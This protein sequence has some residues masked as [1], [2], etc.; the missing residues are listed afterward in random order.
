MSKSVK[1]IRNSIMKLLIIIVICWYLWILLSI[2][3]QCLTSC[4]SSMHCFSYKISDFGLIHW[5]E[6]MN[7]KL[8][9]E[10]LTARGNISYIPPETFTQCPDPPGTTFD[11]YRWLAK[12][13][14]ENCTIRVTAFSLIQCTI[15]N[16]HS[17]T[18]PSTVYNFAPSQVTRTYSTYF[19]HVCLSFIPSYFQWGY[20]IFKELCFYTAKTIS[21]SKWAAQ[22]KVGN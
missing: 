2:V 3:C 16:S 14:F 13:M 1:L 11:V 20:F 19:T 4:Q 9:M 8:F 10:H 5:E 21:L 15:H 12:G 18:S 6:G 17:V 22:M 7:K